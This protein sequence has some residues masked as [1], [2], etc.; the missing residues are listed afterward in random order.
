MHER[1]WVQT[2]ALQDSVGFTAEG[3][4][5]VVGSN[6]PAAVRQEIGTTHLPSR[7][8]LAPVGAAMAGEVAEAFG[9]A[10][11][12]ALQGDGTDEL[13]STLASEMD[14]GAE[15]MLV[16][17]SK[18]FVSGARKSGVVPVASAD[19]PQGLKMASAAARQ[20][21]LTTKDER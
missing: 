17:A 7:P 8:F 13:E 11:T 18:G 14:R 21:G 19:D 9:V 3:L 6:N 2:G 16:S 5:A 1:P 4:S 20:A 15:P 12:K 10:V